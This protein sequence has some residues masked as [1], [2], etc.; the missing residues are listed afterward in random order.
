MDIAEVHEQGAW[1]RFITEQAPEH[2]SF[3][4]SWDWGEVQAGFSRRVH[5]FFVRQ[6]GRPVAAC[7]VVEFDIPM[8]KTF[9]FSPRGPVVLAGV[10]TAGVIGAMKQ[11]LKKEYDYVFWRLE[12]LTGD[13]MPQSRVVPDVEPAVT[14]ILNLSKSEEELLAGM[15]Q[16]TRYN[17]RL[18]EK[19]GVEVDFLTQSNSGAGWAGPAEDFYIMADT[20]AQRHG[21]RLHPKGYYLNMIEVLGEKGELELARATYK[22]KLLGVNILIRFGDTMTYL[23]GASSDEMKNV[24]AP[25]A[26]QWQS[27]RRAKEAGFAWFDFYGIS[28]DDQPEHKLAGVTRFKTG[29]GGETAIY[30]GTVEFPLSQTWYTIYRTVKRL[31]SIL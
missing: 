8:R 2:S 17:I 6:D 31:K 19:K 5:R 20:T 14:S 1:D 4:Q 29:F 30:P 7:L 13:L 27:I 23:H 25:Y 18:A 9:A 3:L 15:K 26:L 22:G 21:I 24:M 28:P 10:D 11:F 12:P 16:K